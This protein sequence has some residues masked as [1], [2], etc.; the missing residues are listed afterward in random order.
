MGSPSTHCACTAG[1]QHGHSLD[2]ANHRSCPDWTLYRH[3]A[4]VRC[5]VY[6]QSRSVED[7]AGQI[8]GAADD[9]RN[10][11]GEEPHDESA[12]GAFHRLRPSGDQA[13][14][15]IEQVSVESDHL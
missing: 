2:P 14:G 11:Y 5:A 7:I 12:G 13:G 10:H 3:I 8:G 4:E 6:G 1:P 9:G 15:K